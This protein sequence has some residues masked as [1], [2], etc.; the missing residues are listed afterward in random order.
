ML[1]SIGGPDDGFLWAPAPGAAARPLSPHALPVPGDVFEPIL[2]EHGVTVT[3]AVYDAQGRPAGGAV[4]YSTQDERGPKVATAADGTFTLHGVA[5]DA[6][7]LFGTPGA[8][9][10]MERTPLVEAPPPPAPPP[11]NTVRVRAPDA[12]YLFFAIGTEG[13]VDPDETGRVELRTPLTGP[14]RISFRHESHGDGEIV[15]DVDAAEVE[16]APTAF[17]VPGFLDAPPDVDVALFDTEGG[18]GDAEG[19]TSWR[20][21]SGTWLRLARAGHAT[22]YRRLSGRGPYVVR[23]GSA[24]LEIRTGDDAVLWVDGERFGKGPVRGLDAGPHKIL[25]GAPGR[26]AKALG[27]A[28][29]GG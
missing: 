27:V 28:L 19:A 4:V 11:S 24:T 8:R 3:G 21:R 17:R 25:V 26:R 23:P 29:K 7:V 16:V 2:L 10:D 14:V 13:S 22:N 18:W 12:G 15:A 1:W 9:A 5:P 20:Y 6:E